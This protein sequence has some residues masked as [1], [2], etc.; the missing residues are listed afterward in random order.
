MVERISF[1]VLP[2]LKGAFLKMSNNLIEL[3]QIIISSDNP[4][5]AV[6]TVADTISDYLRQHEPRQEEIVEFRSADFQI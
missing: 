6:L 3:L 5:K 1:E 4:E 2:K